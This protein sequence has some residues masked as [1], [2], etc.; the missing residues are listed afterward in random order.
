MGESI[1]S[2]PIV[3]ILAVSFCRCLLTYGRTW[4][5]LLTYWE[6]LSSMDVDIFQ[7]LFYI[8]FFQLIWWF[9]KAKLTLYSWDIFQ[10]VM[11][12]S[13]SCN[14]AGLYSLTM[15]KK[16][17]VNKRYWTG[18]F[19]SF[20]DFGLGIREFWLHTTCRK[21]ISPLFSRRVCVGLLFHP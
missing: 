21:M 7:M 13:L 17:Y 9:L 16:L 2:L 3:M 1:F 15:V 18:I 4:L 8:S 12:Y 5:L 20:K 6:L 19:F 11:M 10:L 14:V